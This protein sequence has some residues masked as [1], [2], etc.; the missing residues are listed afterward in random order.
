MLG[1]CWW[2]H[3]KSGLVAFWAKII[4]TELTHSRRHIQTH[5]G[6]NLTVS[7]GD[8]CRCALALFCSGGDVCRCSAVAETSVAV[9]SRCSAVG[10]TCRR[11]CG[12][13]PDPTPG[14]PRAGPPATLGHCAECGIVATPYHRLRS[15]SRGIAHSSWNSLVG[16]GQHNILKRFAI[17]KMRARWMLQFCQGAGNGFY[18]T[19]LAD[20]M[21]LCAVC[22]PWPNPVLDPA[23][24]G[25]STRGD[26]ERSHRV[27]GCSCRGH[28]TV[29]IDETRDEARPRLGTSGC[30]FF[31]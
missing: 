6:H 27:T 30:R 25:N 10:H 21:T 4:R 15:S 18:K 24:P 19:L 14:V 29:R 20:V 23:R 3:L 13:V 31:D 5:L 26:K 8:V 2:R 7:V 1:P 12:R 28:G 22:T 11:P 9:R 16:Q 17:G